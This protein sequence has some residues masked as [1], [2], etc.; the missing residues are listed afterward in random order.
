MTSRPESG[1]ADTIFFPDAAAFE[2]W[3]A[4]HVDHQPGVWLKI[5]KKSSGI[6]SLTDNRLHDLYTPVVG[7]DFTV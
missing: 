3:L 1:T 7:L 5:A 6:A 4:E 2:A